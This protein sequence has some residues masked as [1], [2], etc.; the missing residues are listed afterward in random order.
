[1]ENNVL[2]KSS[3]TLSISFDHGA[4]TQ[5]PSISLAGIIVVSLLLAIFLVSLFIMASYASISSRWTDQL[6]SFAMM[7]IGASI[8]DH[9][10]LKIGNRT[11]EM[12]VLDE[13]PGCIGNAAEENEIGR[14][15]LGG[16]NS[17]AKEKD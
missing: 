14:L 9:V 3:H 1:M 11:H 2:P 15:A 16:E 12:S 13:I 7:R 10:P 17:L 4:D 8:A 5:I 6:D